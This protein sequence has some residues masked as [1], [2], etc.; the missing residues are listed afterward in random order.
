ML[1]PVIPQR[2]PSCSPPF[3]TL[4][5]T[6]GLLLLP[7]HLHLCCHFHR[8]T[9][10]PSQLRGHNCRLLQSRGLHHRLSTSHVMTTLGEHDLYSAC[11]LRFGSNYHLLGSDS[12]QCTTIH[13]LLLI[14][15]SSSLGVHNSAFQSRTPGSPEHLSSLSGSPFSL[16]LFSGLS[17]FYTK[18]IPV[19]VH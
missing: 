4:I 11:F 18:P 14:T 15:S 6:N 12:I 2:L 3:S 5:K 10:C 13:R 1:Q 17:L 7:L 19:V 9:G 8:W 16:F